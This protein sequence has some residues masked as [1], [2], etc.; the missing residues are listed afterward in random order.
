MRARVG[1]IR[2]GTPGGDA[3]TFGHARGLGWP[4]VLLM[5]GLLIALLR[6]AD[7]FGSD[8]VRAELGKDTAWTGEPVPLVI[9]LYSPGPF[10]GT[11]SFDWPE[12]PAVAFV[13]AGNPLVG[14]ER[15]G[16]ES[17]FT[18][19]HEFAI[20]TQ[21]TGAMVIPAFRVRFAGKQTFTSAAE[22]MEGFTPELRFRSVRPPGTESLGVVVAARQMEVSQT[23]QPDSI[24][25]VRPGDVIT[26]TIVRRA[27]GA[28]AMMLP[29][30]GIETPPGVRHYVSDP[31]VRDFTER[32]AS[33]AVRS[34]TI[35]YQ[36]ERSGTFQLPDLPVIWWDPDAQALKRV[37]LPGK[38]I[39]VD[40][41]EV[42]EEPPAPT[43][44]HRWPLAVLLLSLVMASGM[45]RKPAARWLAARRTRRNDAETVAARRLLA[46]CQSNAA[47]EAYAAGLQ[48]KRAAGREGES[49]SERL[50]L[51]VATDFEHEWSLLSRHEYGAGEAIPPWTGERLAGAFADLR[52]A[53]G[54]TSRAR[55]AKGGLPA[56]NPSQPATS[57]EERP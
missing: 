1:K 28:T 32:G 42:F 19:R 48:W 56:L 57:R 34:E 33:L 45:L 44:E 52:R 47:A 15:I 27:T 31:T 53:L 4:N 37:N 7:S 3:C 11:A 36:F 40:V 9:T 23:W 24:L 55:N 21:R 50:P 43:S 14:S 18:Q 39:D 25:S 46:A 35:K 22:P 54:R 5:L 16:S 51:G 6:P 38:K 30:V 17:Y 49:L 13:Q 10:S 29:P 26:R 8:L 20:Y 12:L 2:P 41:E